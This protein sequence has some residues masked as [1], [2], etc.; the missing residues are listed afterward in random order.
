MKRIDEP[1]RLWLLLGWA[2]FSVGA[3]LFRDWQ[4]TATGAMVIIDTH[5]QYITWLIT[6]RN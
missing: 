4:I 2:L 5:L 1:S 3:W 6:P